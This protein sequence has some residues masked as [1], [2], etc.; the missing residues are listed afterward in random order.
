[1]KVFVKKF[2][3]LLLVVL[4]LSTSI[5]IKLYFHECLTCHVIDFSFIDEVSACHQHHLIHHINHNHE[6]KNNAMEQSVDNDCCVATEAYL[7]YHYNNTLESPFELSSKLDFVA[8]LFHI[9]TVS[10]SSLI[11][12][13][14]FKHYF[15][16]PPPAL[17]SG[18]DFLKS[19]QQLKF[20]CFCLA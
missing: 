13:N 12:L 7:Q 1:M 5:G 6:H 8:I 9:D 20:D 14:N 15:V 17:I 18:I 4:T 16:N 3:A 19:I 10:V 2:F 11:G